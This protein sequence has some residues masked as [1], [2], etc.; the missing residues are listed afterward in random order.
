MT[1]R[2]YVVKDTDTRPARPS[3]ALDEIKEQGR[4]IARLVSTLTDCDRH[5]TEDV[6]HAAVTISN[7]AAQVEVLLYQRDPAAGPEVPF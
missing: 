4:M 2:L 7:A 3:T 5:D 6:F 1:P